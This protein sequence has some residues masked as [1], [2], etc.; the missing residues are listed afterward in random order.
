MAAFGCMVFTKIAVSTIL[1][2]V[3]LTCAIAQTPATPQEIK[4]DQMARK[5]VRLLNEHQPDSIYA[6]AGQA[7]RQQI[8][9]VFFNQIYQ[10]Q[11]VPLLPI[12]KIAFKSSY[13]GINTYKIEGTVNLTMNISL[14]ALGMIENFSF[15]PYVEEAKPLAMTDAEKRTDELAMKILEYLN[16]K[17]PDMVY[18][19][20]GEKFRSV[21]D[22]VAFHNIVEK[23]LYPLLPLQ[24][25]VFIG[26]KNG[27]S[28]YKVGPLQLLISLDKT[29]RFETLGIQPYSDDAK[30]AEKVATDNP[31]HSKMDSVVDKLLSAYI[32]TK[33]NVGLS[34]AVYY[35]GADHYYN[36]GETKVGTHELPDAHTLYE[37][38]SI[39]KTFTATLLAKAV[40]DGLVTLDDHITK[41]LPDSV[42]A[43][44]DISTITLRELSNHTSGLPRMPDN[45]NQTVT[46]LKQ[47]YEHYD[48]AHMF[49]FLKSFKSV[50]PA[51]ASYEYSNLAQGLLGVILER[52]YH[53][54]YEELLKLYITTPLQLNNTKIRLT[55]MDVK[56]LA[57]GYDETYNP[58]AIWRQ[59]S[60]KAAGAIKSDAADMLKYGKYQLA[61][62][63]NLLSKALKL[64]HQQTLDDGVNK[65]GLGWHYLHAD[66]DPVIQHSGG[67][68][69][70]RTAIA[71]NLNRDLVV[72]V[73]TNNASTGDAVG[74]NLMTALEKAL[75]K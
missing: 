55:E 17:Q 25:P 60:T 30:K 65:V 47:P 5:A 59:M 43:N 28:K 75:P 73:L 7:F 8:T 4:T 58:V 56:H 36:Y 12:K 2:F 50:R 74:L 72:V 27:L 57:Q 21:M 52:I 66:A 70:Y 29:G 35:N 15:V 38:G 32:Q 3:N 11:F 41:F 6:L 1:V 54:P 24:K 40:T 13:Q 51:G 46:D 61:S 67:T 49:A 39:T 23:Q 9:A 18:P 20:A 26:S 71:V 33:G 68:G 44:V 64:T 45:I 42:A 19:F 53:K 69:G 48:E 37:I 14:D 16:N 34:A 31:M 10:K 22:S 63:N 62:H